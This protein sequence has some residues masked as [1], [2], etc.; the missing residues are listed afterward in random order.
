MVKFESL[1]PEIRGVLGKKVSELGLRVEGSPVEGYVRQLYKELEH[2]AF[3]RRALEPKAELA[4]LLAKHAPD[5]GVQGLKLD[6]A[7]DYRGATDH[8]CCQ[9]RHWCS[10]C[11]VDMHE[12]RTRT[13]PAAA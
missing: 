4:D 8:A 3:D 11:S 5:L 13:R 10:K 1:D 6:H 7:R 12:C 2:I 9:H